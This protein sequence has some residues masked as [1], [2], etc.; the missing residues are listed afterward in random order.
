[1]HFK[2][3]IQTLEKRCLNGYGKDNIMETKKK[4][5]K[6]RNEKRS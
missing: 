3:S 4:N 1:M 6:K 5:E 2:Y